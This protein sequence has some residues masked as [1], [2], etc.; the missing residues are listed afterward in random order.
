MVDWAQ[1]SNQLTYCEYPNIQNTQEIKRTLFILTKQDKM[2]TFSRKSSFFSQP[3]Y[4]IKQ[5]KK[6][7]PPPS[8][9]AQLIQ[10][11]LCQLDVGDWRKEK[12]TRLTDVKRTSKRT[13]SKICTFCP[14]S[15]V[16]KRAFH[17]LSALDLFFLFFFFRKL[18]VNSVSDLF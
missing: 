2:C 5:K 18:A 11:I 16:K 13:S 14:V 3:T 7:R 17:L 12:G 10:L 9:H 4:N 8:P 1:S 15:S 6:E